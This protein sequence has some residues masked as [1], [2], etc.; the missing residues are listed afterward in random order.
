MIGSIIGTNT[1]NTIGVN[2]ANA[3]DAI[4]LMVTIRINGRLVD[5][6]ASQKSMKFWLKH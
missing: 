1:T 2:A 3:I 6:R 5:Q 4:S